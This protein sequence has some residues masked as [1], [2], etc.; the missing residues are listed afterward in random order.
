MTCAL[1]SWLIHKIAN[2]I[3]GKVPHCG[4]NSIQL[5]YK[6]TTVPSIKKVRLPPKSGVSRAAPAARNDERE[7]MK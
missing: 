4:C 6:F 2:K 1:C 5:R 7:E 3:C